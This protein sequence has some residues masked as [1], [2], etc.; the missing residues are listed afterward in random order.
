MS[1]LVILLILCSTFM[2]A[3]WNLLARKQRNEEVFFNRMLFITVLIG[4]LPAVLD[5]LMSGMLSGKV[6]AYV[7]GSGLCCA[8]Y[9]F[10][11]AQAYRSSDFSV[12]YPV[13]RAIPVLLIGFGDVLRGR[14]LTAMGWIGVLLISLGCLL[15]PLRCFSEVNIRRYLRLPA[16]TEYRTEEQGTAE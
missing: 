16:Y 8:I 4:S 1:G 11:L 7:V 2:H 10:C 3:G 6:W 15:A 14:N 5:A 13:A 12:V 9:Y